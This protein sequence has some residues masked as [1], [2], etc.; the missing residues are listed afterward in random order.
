MALTKAQ[1]DRFVDVKGIRIHYNEAGSGPALI[2]THGGGPGAN[3]WDN[4][5][6]CFDQ[7]AQH[8]R[9]ILMDMPGFGESQMGVSRGGVPMDV[10]LARLQRDFLD[11]LEI[12]RAHLYGSSAFSATT[13]RFG[14]EYPERTGKLV[15]QAFSAGA[16]KGET[17]GLKSLIAFSQNPIREN[18]ETMMRFFTPRPEFR[19]GDVVDARFAAATRPGHLQS[20][21]E[22][23]A[24]ANS[25]DLKDQLGNLKAP[26]LVV[27]GYRD[28][29]IPVAEVMDDLERIPDVRAHIWGGQS[30]HFVVHE[31]PE[32]FARLVVDFLSH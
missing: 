19:S 18:M 22:F 10:F 14:L 28:G 5:K 29:M 1:T 27:W 24:S 8:F 26:V 3:A 2:C 4:T 9:T 31:H 20:R 30:G 7:L 12:D 11:A 15:I 25:P 16:H 32:E 21:R 13:L 23:A 6:W 17:E